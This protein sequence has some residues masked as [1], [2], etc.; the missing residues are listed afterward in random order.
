MLATP[1]ELLKL[2]EECAKQENEDKA[3]CKQLALLPGLPSGSPPPT[4]DPTVLPTVLP[5][6]LPTLLPRAGY[7]PRIEFGQRGPT[8]AQL[9]ELYDPTL[10]SLL[11]PGMV[12]QKRKAP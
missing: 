12:T 11:V 5:T 2:K 3:V 7:G 9:M 10:V 6:F 1:E 4:L 8:I